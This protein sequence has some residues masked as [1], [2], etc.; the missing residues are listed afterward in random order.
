MTEINYDLISEIIFTNDITFTDIDIEKA[1]MMLCIC[2]MARNNKNILLSFDKVKVKKY[3]KEIKS[4]SKKKARKMIYKWDTD[5]MEGEVNL[6]INNEY[7]TKIINIIANISNENAYIIECVKNVMHIEQKK[8]IDKIIKSLKKIISI[9]E[10]LGVDM[11]NIT[12]DDRYMCQNN[13]EYIKEKYNRIEINT[14]FKYNAYFINMLSNNKI[15]EKT[16]I[17]Y[18]SSE[19][20]DN[21]FYRLPIIFTRYMIDNIYILA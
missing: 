3:C 11:D 20:F 9:I 17:N 1:K 8:I 19:Y 16:I 14:I 12:D 21:N 6:D 2:K 4:I 7:K 18:I 13:L 15:S 5:D 10:S